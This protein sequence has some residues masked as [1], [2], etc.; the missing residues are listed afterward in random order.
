MLTSFPDLKVGLIVNCLRSGSI[1]ELAEAAIADTSAVNLKGRKT[2]LYV[3]QGRN[4][5]SLS[6]IPSP[7]SLPVTVIEGR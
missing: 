5:D 4:P 3:V 7:E 2:P 6:F 1:G